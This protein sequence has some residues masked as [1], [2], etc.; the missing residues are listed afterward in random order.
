M[1]PS[2]PVAPSPAPPRLREIAEDPEHFLKDVP[3]PVR[4][5]IAPRFTIVF[6]PSNTH[7]VTMRLRTR[8]EDLDAVI[9]EVRSA[10]REV[11]HTRNVW[12]V[13]PSCRPHGLGPLLAERGFVPATRPPFEASVTAM[14]LET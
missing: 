1:N 10:V 5:L 9:A 6:A 11:G 4:R 3:P 13:G 2:L 8:A 12:Q 14:A 7:S